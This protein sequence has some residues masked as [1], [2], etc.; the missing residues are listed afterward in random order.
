MIV[1][2]IENIYQENLSFPDNRIMARLRM[3]AT[4]NAIHYIIFNKNYSMLNNYQFKKD[5]AFDAEYDRI[6]RLRG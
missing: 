1:K 5:S 3:L 6:N 4:L 2:T